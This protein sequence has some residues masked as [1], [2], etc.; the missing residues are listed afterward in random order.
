MGISGRGRVAQALRAT[1]FASIVALALSCTS[2]ASAALAD[3]WEG[4]WERTELPGKHLFLTQTGSAVSGSYDWNDASGRV[5][6]GKV[7]GATLTA[8][9]KETHYEGSF[10][11]TLAG[12]RFSGSYT[13]K[14]RDTGGSIEGPFDGTCVAGACLAN[15]APLPESGAPAP[16]VVAAPSSWNATSAAV[17]VLPGG[18][19]ASASPPLGNT[20]RATA[21]AYGL[22]PEDVAYALLKSAKAYCYLKAARRLAQA[23]Y[24]DQAELLTLKERDALQPALLNVGFFEVGFELTDCLALAERAVAE[25]LAA[26]A[27]VHPTAAAACPLTG[28]QIKAKRI[29]GKRRTVGFAIASDKDVAVSCSYKAGVLTL[30]VASRSGKPL[31][32]LIGPRLAIG[33]AHSRRRPTEKVSFRYHKG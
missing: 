21:T 29:N 28:V 20:L 32:R 10:I 23:A 14:N 25:E 4:T 18:A 24:H 13:G 31:R 9:F 2:S 12:K 33:V 11:L 16:T 26:T 3:T 17:G 22:D 19:A 30:R 7:S 8:G 15:G 6:E 5:L 27:S 1:C